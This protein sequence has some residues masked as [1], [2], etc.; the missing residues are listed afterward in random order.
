MRCIGSVS[1]LPMRWPRRTG[2][3]STISITAETNDQRVAALTEL[4]RRRPAALRSLNP[5]IPESLSRI[6]EKSLALDPR[7][8]FADADELAAAVRAEYGVARRAVR[9]AGRHRRL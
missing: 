8:R 1:S 5:R 4:Q 9:W 3:E 2:T 6:V 7:A